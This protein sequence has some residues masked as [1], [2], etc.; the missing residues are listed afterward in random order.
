M[1]VSLLDLAY[2]VPAGKSVDLLSKGFNYDIK[3]LIKSSK[4]GSLFKK[5]DKIKIVAGPQ[6]IIK[7][8]TYQLSKQPI[9]T[10]KRS[11]VVVEEQVFED[12]WMFSD[13]KYAE[14]MSEE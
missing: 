7:D 13:E 6:E 4:S 1:N 9:Q 11:A 3:T 5:R 8:E 12:E 2:T 14:E 10:K